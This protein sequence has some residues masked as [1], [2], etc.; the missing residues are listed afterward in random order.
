MTVTLPC[1][2][3][4]VLEAIEREHIGAALRQ[5]ADKRSVAAELLGLKRTTLVEKLRRLGYATRRVER[6]P[7][8]E[9]PIEGG[10]GI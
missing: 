2:L 5:A 9:P 1:R 8:A 3:A 7:K 4:D 10:A 6:E